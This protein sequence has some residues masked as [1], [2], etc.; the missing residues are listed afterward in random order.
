M[1]R[2]DGSL[3]PFDTMTPEEAREAGRRGGIASGE[4]RRKKKAMKE[5]LNTIMDM[6]LKGNARSKKVEAEDVISFAQLKGKNIDVQ[7]AI[8]IAQIKN[9]LQG[10]TTAA[11]F[12][13]DT[14]GENPSNK[15]DITGNIP[16]VIK[17]DLEDNDE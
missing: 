13:R 10:D 11:T 1:P 9:A 8:I 15:V 17:D 7:T 2:Q 12:L 3:T 5:V 4:A 14:A 16:V 6:P